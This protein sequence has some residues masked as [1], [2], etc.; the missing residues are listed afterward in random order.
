ME[1]GPVELSAGSSSSNIRSTA[2]LMVS[3]R[4][5]VIKGEERAFFQKATYG[6]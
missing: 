6:D 5:R 3:G 2:K 4:T 1:P